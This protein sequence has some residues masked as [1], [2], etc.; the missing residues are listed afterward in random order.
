MNAKKIV[1]LEEL[2]SQAYHARRRPSLLARLQAKRC[3][4]FPS[5]TFER[6]LVAADR[7]AFSRQLRRKGK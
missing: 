6:D 5:G 3:A 7:L 1:R 4:A 2:I